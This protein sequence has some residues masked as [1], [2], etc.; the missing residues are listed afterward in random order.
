MPY[1]RFSNQSGDTVYVCV[2]SN[3]GEGETSYF[4]LADGASDGWQRNTGPV[5]A[6]V[7]RSSNGAN[8]KTTNGLELGVTYTIGSDLKC[9]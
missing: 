7:S 4:E 1:V 9:T 6:F 3:G 5:S 2:S 8:A